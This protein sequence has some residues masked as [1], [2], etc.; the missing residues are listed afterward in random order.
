MKYVINENVKVGGLD[1]R[2]LD[3]NEDGT[4]DLRELEGDGE[5][6]NIMLDKP[7]K[8]GFSHKD[9]ILIITEKNEGDDP[10]I[11]IHSF[12]S[13][14]N[15]IAYTKNDIEFTTRNISLGGSIVHETLINPLNPHWYCV[16]T[17][18][19]QY[20]W[21]IREIPC[22]TTADYDAVDEVVEFVKV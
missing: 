12:D 1:Y 19:T 8:I 9:Y 15:A 3:I 17:N 18:G 6:N 2:I 7:T 14:D 21:E 13:L 10:N 22:R 20:N 11:M 5:L 4:Y 16:D